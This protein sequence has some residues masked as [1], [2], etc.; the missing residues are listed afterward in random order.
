[1]LSSCA[2]IEDVFARQRFASR[3]QGH[4]PGVRFMRITKGDDV[5]KQ[6]RIALLL[7]GTCC[8]MAAMFEWIVSELQ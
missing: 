7:A 8:L 2:D 3:L 5:G 6:A 4:L 1:M